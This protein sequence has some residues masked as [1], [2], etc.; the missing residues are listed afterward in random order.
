MAASQAYDP[1]SAAKLD[2]V[3]FVGQPLDRLDGLAKVTGQAKYAYEY[4]TSPRVAIGFIVEASIAKG[5][6]LQLDTMLAERAPGVRLVMTHLNAP[7][8]AAFGPPAAVNRNARARPVLVDVEVLY[9]GQ[10]IALVVADTFEQA[11]AAAA[12]IH[13]RYDRQQAALTLEDNLDNAY[14][15]ERVGPGL[16][17]DSAPLRTICGI[18]P[19]TPNA[20]G[21]PAIGAAIDAMLPAICAAVSTFG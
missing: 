12:L 20:F 2:A 9:F 7:K 16:A 13:A 21:A 8:Q 18:V 11:R 15:P 14:R 6:I 4:Q 1:A 10:P 19:T 5:R 3:T 17:P